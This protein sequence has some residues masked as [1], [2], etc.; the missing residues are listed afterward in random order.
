MEDISK[1][2][3]KVR[4]V[5]QSTEGGADV[6][7]VLQDVLKRMVDADI[8]DLAKM[9][10]QSGAKK[11]RRIFELATCGTRSRDVVIG[12]TLVRG[13]NRGGTVNNKTAL[14]FSRDPRNGGKEKTVDKKG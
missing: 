5:N 10:Y 4:V 9:A 3:G 11:D 2:D 8:P 7:N 1:N 12:G 14:S 6:V 13:A